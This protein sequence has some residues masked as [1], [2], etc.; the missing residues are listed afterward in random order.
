MLTPCLLYRQG[1]VF[2]LNKYEITRK[3]KW[4]A[5]IQ[6]LLAAFIIYSATNLLALLLETNTNEVQ[7]Q[8]QATDSGYSIRVVG[9][10]NRLEDQQQKELVATSIYTHIQAEKLYNESVQVAATSIYNFIVE[11]YPQTPIHLSYGQQIIPP[12]YVDNE[13]YPQSMQQAIVVKLGSGRG[14]NWF[15]ALFSNVCNPPDYEEQ[16]Q[17]QQQEQQIDWFF[18]RFFHKQQA[19]DDK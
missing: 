4:L 16:Q 9:N 5:I 14:D 17:E 13:L 10:S 11:N 7:A 8:A 18:L 1:G 12:K 6:F 15:C 3:P 19:E 2:M